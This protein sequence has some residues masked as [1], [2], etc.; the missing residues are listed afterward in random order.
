VH[1]YS[2]IY[3]SHVSYIVSIRSAGQW[4]NCLVDLI[5][6]SSPNSFKGMLTQRSRHAYSYCGAAGP[7]GVILLWRFANYQDKTRQVTTL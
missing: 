3:S 1:L 7:I 5:E 4:N 2:F 6:C